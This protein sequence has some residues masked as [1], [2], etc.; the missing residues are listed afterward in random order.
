MRLSAS[1]CIHAGAISSA[2]TESAHASVSARPASAGMAR[3]GGARRLPVGCSRPALPSLRQPKHE[4]AVA[5][6][7]AKLEVAAGGDGD[8]LLTVDLERDRRGVDAGA[9][10]EPQELFTGLGVEGIERAGAVAAGEDHSPPVARAPPMS[11][12]G[13][14]FCQPIFPVLTSIAVKV[15]HC[16]SVGIATKALPS[17]SFPRSNGV[18][19]VM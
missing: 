14:F 15:P 16:A 19:C 1:T 8:E 4:D 9:A 17:H 6:R 13:S 10:L 12:S 2:W 18:E 3:G 11:G 7:E 5:V